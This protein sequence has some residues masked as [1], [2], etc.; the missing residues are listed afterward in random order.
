M[1]G[2]TVREHLRDS[3]HVFSR[4]GIRRLYL[5]FSVELIS[6]LLKLRPG[7]HLVLWKKTITNLIILISSSV[8]TSLTAHHV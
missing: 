6:F 5:V 1:T 2:V 8:Y 7:R 4:T 3:G